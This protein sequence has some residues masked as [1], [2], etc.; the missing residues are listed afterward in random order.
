MKQSLKQI[1]KTTISIPEEDIDFM[2]ALFKPLSLGKEGYF[3]KVGNRCN[4]VAFINSGILRNYYPNEKGEE[5]T[6]HFALP[7][8]FITSFPSLTT[9]NPSTE[10]IQA[11]SPAELLVIDKQD[12]EML[13]EKIPATQEFG[14]KAA[15]NLTITMEK[16]I[17]L[18]LNNTAEE[19]YHFLMKYNPILIQTVPLQYLATYLGITPQHLSRLRK[20]TIKSVF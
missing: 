1:I 14:R 13:Y 7:N 6:C 9:N 2:L 15:E 10:N 16:R 5:T 20:N 19:R 8:D 11:L 12:L 4:Q 18:F 3:L 17:A